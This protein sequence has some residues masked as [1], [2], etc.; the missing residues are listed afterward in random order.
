MERLAETPPAFL[1]L[2]AIQVLLLLHLLDPQE[3]SNSEVPPRPVVP[4]PQPFNLLDKA[5][6]F[7]PLEALLQMLPPLKEDSI[8]VPPLPALQIFRLDQMPLN[9]LSAP[10]L[11]IQTSCQV[12]SVLE[13][14]HPLLPHQINSFRN[15][16]QHLNSQ[17]ECLASALDHLKTREVDKLLELVGQEDDYNNHLLF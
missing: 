14:Q 5:H 13:V 7:R 6:L 2:V 1:L 3:C 17:E 4:Q 9:L 8:L 10:Q 12:D 16:Q 15:P 11:K